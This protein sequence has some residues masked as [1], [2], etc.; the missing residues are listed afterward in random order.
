[1]KKILVLYYSRTGITKVLAS[2]IAKLL[3]ADLEE[4]VDTKKRT[5]WM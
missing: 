3:N 1:M 2:Y 4:I 5:G